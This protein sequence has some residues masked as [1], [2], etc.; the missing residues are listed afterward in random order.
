M[1]DPIYKGK[2]INPLELQEDI[3]QL[4]TLLRQK[5]KNFIP[6]GGG[7]PVELK[8]SKFFNTRPQ[9]L[10]TNYSSITKNNTAQTEK[11]VE[12]L[13]SPLTL[14]LLT[15]LNVI[16]QYSADAETS[17][18]EVFA[19]FYSYD[20]KTNDYKKE[21]V[22][23]LNPSTD[24]LVDGVPLKGNSPFIFNSYL[25]FSN[26]VEDTNIRLLPSE[27]GSS[28]IVRAKRLSLLLWPQN[29]TDFLVTNDLF[30]GEQDRKQIESVELNNIDI[31]I[32]SQTPFVVSPI[33]A[34]HFPTVQAGKD[35]GVWIVHNRTM[36]VTTAI[37]TDW[38]N[39]YPSL[40]GV[41]RIP[42]SGWLSGVTQNFLYY[43]CVACVHINSEGKFEVSKELAWG[44]KA[45]TQNGDYAYTEIYQQ[46]SEANFTLQNSTIPE[47]R[48]IIPS[49]YY[50]YHI[51]PSFYSLVNYSG[52][53]KHVPGAGGNQV[54][55]TLDSPIQNST[56]TC[57]IKIGSLEATDSKESIW[58]SDVNLNL[59]SLNPQVNNGQTELDTGTFTFGQSYYVWLVV[60]P[61]TILDK[62]TSAPKKNLRMKLLL[63][64]SDT[65][66]GVN[67]VWKA[68]NTG[69]IF[70]S[71]LFWIN[72]KSNGEIKPFYMRDGFYRFLNLPGAANSSAG[73]V[74]E[75][76]DQGVL[77]S[78]TTSVP[79]YSVISSANSFPTNS[80]GTI[81]NAKHISGRLAITTGAAST[82]ESRIGISSTD[83]GASPGESPNWSNP[84][85]VGA[86]SVVG[87][88][89]TFKN[90]TS[91]RTNI[92]TRYSLYLN[93]DSQI[94]YA[95]NL[96]SDSGTS[97]T[98]W[99]IT[100][101]E[102]TLPINDGYCYF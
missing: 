70:R 50:L 35:F 21:D 93:P 78:G 30:K 15:K 66:S 74:Y 41:V 3:R 37:L 77:L 71:R 58:I 40:N 92:Q 61:F 65:W 86:E 73:V 63:S 5:V 24:K 95:V 23:P 83:Y 96:G 76:S 85:L 94:L 34:G 81:L 26:F 79:N 91:I 27:D 49:Y 82:V 87:S 32:G 14:D 22:Y 28:L 51:N 68:N 56:P 60:N 48:R 1:L 89:Q 36:Q 2:P 98:K 9:A 52:I 54:E 100:L 64:R 17:A 8:A 80:S 39:P 13:G 97:G 53:I 75:F 11:T 12:W 42:Y 6:I 43:R 67:S 4:F 29:T 47:D 25:G 18:G 10:N 72:T 20:G 7:L 88:L 62:S 55:V 102:M 99:F 59:S 57:V 19:S 44:D 101:D 69:Y 45:T 16:R 46:N 33:Q 31:T 90:G 38:S 84:Y